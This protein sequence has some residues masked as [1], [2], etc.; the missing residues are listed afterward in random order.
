MIQ[1]WQDEHGTQYAHGTAKL[2]KDPRFNDSTRTKVCSFSAEVEN[3]P[4]GEKTPAGKNKYENTLYTFTAFGALALYCK[5]LEKKDVV[6]FYGRMEVDDYWT[7]R[8]QT[9]EVVY[10]II[11]EFCS[12]QPT[13]G[14]AGGYGAPGEF[15][16]LP[17]DEYF[18]G[19]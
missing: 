3:H 6:A 16:D 14:G 8:N 1:I 7:E 2:I 4:T 5:D 10:K 15:Y 9:G 12:V 17:D 18:P 13:N 11:L 19:D